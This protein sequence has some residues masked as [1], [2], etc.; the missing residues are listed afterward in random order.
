MAKTNHLVLYFGIVY[1]F[2]VKTK[3]NVFNISYSIQKIFKIDTTPAVEVL[4]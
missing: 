4:T 1:F 3:L 2:A